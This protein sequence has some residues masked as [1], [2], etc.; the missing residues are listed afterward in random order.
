[1]LAVAVA[2]N[3]LAAKNKLK[4]GQSEIHGGLVEEVVI[5]GRNYLTRGTHVADVL[6]VCRISRGGEKSE[7]E[8]DEFHFFLETD[9]RCSADVS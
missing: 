5:R 9:V 6:R 8:H 4:R 7:G 2:T 3:E 1:M